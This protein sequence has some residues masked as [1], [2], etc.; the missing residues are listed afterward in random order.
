MVRSAIIDLLG[1]HVVQNVDVARKY[2]AAIVD[3]ISDVG[4]SVRKR[5]I[6]ILHDCLRS[7]PDFIHK[8][9]ALRCLAF[10]ILD[11]DVGI[12]ELV[13]RVFRDLWFSP[14]PAPRDKAGLHKLN[15]V[16]P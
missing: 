2:Y 6:N 10:R 8:I 12:Q 1:K 3:R 11:D 5:V 14:L 13:V 4:V 15:A 9:G 16:D 7:S